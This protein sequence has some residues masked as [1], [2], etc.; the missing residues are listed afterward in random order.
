MDLYPPGKNPAHAL[1]DIW[2]AL[3]EDSVRRVP[4]LAATPASRPRWVS[5]CSRW[6]VEWP[7]GSPRW[8][9]RYVGVD[10][11]DLPV[12]AYGPRRGMYFRP[13]FCLDARGRFTAYI[14][15]WGDRHGLL[16]GTFLDYSILRSRYRWAVVCRDRLTWSML[17]DP[18][19][20][21]HNLRESILNNLSHGWYGLAADDFAMSNNRD[22]WRIVVPDCVCH[23]NE[24]PCTC[25]QRRDFAS[26]QMNIQDEAIR[27]HYHHLLNQERAKRGLPLIRRSTQPA[28]LH[29]GNQTLT[30]DD[31]V[32]LISAL[33][34][35]DAPM[36]PRTRLTEAHK[37]I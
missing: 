17:N 28:R 2:S 26:M 13:V 1:Y 24:D 23:P 21:R 25:S 31:S 5:D 35:V 29:N 37:E 7:W 33:M 3:L 22:R 36:S 18:R 30:G 9:V 16:A 4:Y 32:A 12:Y 6:S 8:M 10:Q 27:R 20:Q 15:T 14:Q 19:D 11:F 34:R